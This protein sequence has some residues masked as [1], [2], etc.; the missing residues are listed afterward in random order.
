MNPIERL[1]S[2]FL[3]FIK[4]FLSISNLGRKVSGVRIGFKKTER[5]LLLGQ[6]VIMFG[7]IFYDKMNKEMVISNPKFFA[8][9]KF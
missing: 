2:W 6:L 8:K 5:G 4:L 9:S 7:D 1:L 3:F